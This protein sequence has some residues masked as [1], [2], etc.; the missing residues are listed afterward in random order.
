MP[1][2]PG[3]CFSLLEPDGKKVLAAISNTRAVSTIG[4]DATCAFYGFDKSSP[5]IEETRDPDGTLY[6]YR[7][8]QITSQGFRVTNARIQLVD[9]DPDSICKLDIDRRIARYR[10]SRGYLM[11]IGTDV[12]RQLR[13]FFARKEGKIYFTA[14]DVAAKEPVISIQAAQ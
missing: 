3:S 14:A 7:A 11:S 12:L 4:T 5:G 6:H 2:S 9:Q 1:V 13:L 10:C 8:M